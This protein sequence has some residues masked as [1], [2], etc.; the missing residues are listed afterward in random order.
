VKGDLYVGSMNVRGNTYNILKG[1]DKLRE[2][3]FYGRKILNMNVN[4]KY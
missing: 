1:R 2:L 3:S 4:I